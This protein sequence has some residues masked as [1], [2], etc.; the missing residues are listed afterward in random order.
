MI[1]IDFRPICEADIPFLTEL[2]ISTRWEELQ[3]V[4]W[5]AEEK[6][7]FLHWQFQA[8]HA[9]YQKYFPN[10]Q[11]YILTHQNE[12]IGRLYL[13]RRDDEIRIV[14]IALVPQYRN[15]GIGSHLLQ[16][17]MVD[18]KQNRLAIRIHVEN[19]N[20]A[21]N[22]YRRLGFCKVHQDG[23]YWLMEWKDT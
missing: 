10:A 18:A 16:E 7:H 12:A 6:R 20:P 11:F 4:P 21:M 13:D 22:L 5:T 23:I 8:Q 3:P 19:N 14:D 2:Y 17:L 15:Q 9:H 1:S